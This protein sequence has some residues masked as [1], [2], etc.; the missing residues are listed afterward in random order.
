MAKRRKI[1]RVSK[2]RLRFF[3]TLCVLVIFYSL[4]LTLYNGYTIYQL[5]IEKNKLEQKLLNLQEESE[6]LR[7]DISKLNDEEYLANYAREHYMYSKDGEYIIHIEED[8]KDKIEN[9]D[10]EISKNYITIG[11]VI[12]VAFIFIYI[13]KKSKKK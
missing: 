6:N 12:V 9:I 10:A 8:E 1:S 2:R 3:G 11:L 4:F 7:T 13:I 5:S